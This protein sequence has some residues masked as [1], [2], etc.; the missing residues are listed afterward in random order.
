MKENLKM[1]GTLYFLSHDY[2]CVLQQH[3]WDSHESLKLIRFRNKWDN[4]CNKEGERPLTG[5]LYQTSV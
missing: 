3:P 2:L 4:T 1:V 5:V